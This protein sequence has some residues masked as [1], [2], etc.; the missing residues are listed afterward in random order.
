M[1]TP[2][3]R[4]FLDEVGKVVHH[5]NS[6]AVGLSAVERGLAT[7]PMELDISWHPAD[8]IASGRQARSFALRS[9]IVM[10]SELLGEYI[11]QVASFPSC[12]NLVLPPKG[13]RDQ[14]LE[15]VKNFFLFL[16][17]NCFLAHF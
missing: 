4:Q 13:E 6:I 3:L 15:A 7:K 9:T 2:A 8:L 16:N 12:K 11:A 5:L 10:V 1:Q 14:K 17:L